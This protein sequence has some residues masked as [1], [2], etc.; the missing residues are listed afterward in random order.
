MTR[1]AA[2]DAQLG[3]QLEEVPQRRRAGVLRSL[4]LQG[5]PVGVA[6]ALER[7]KKAG[8][9]E[10]LILELFRTLAPKRLTPSEAARAFPMWPLTSVRRA[11]SNLA[12][13]GALEHH[14]KD[15]RPGPFGAK[16]STWSLRG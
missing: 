5:Q 6:E 2:S 16:E 14:A 15:R 1:Q 13:R 10:A 3:L 11:I 12:H 4:H 7:D 9:Q 8:R